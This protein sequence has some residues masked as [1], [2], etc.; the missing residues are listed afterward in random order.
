MV[1]SNWQ[2]EKRLLWNPR[3]GNKFIV[4][5]G[6][7]I[8]LY[9]WT[10]EYPEIR[11]I[12]S[13]H[14]L[15]YM[16][17]FAW[18][19]DPYFDD[20]VAVGNS[21]GRVDL[22]RL[23]ASKYARRNNVL[24]M[25]PTISFPLRNSR[26]CNAL[27]FC[28]AD[29]NYL[30]V[31]LDKAR[32]DCSL[33]IYDIASSLPSMA[34][35]MDPV[36]TA[37]SASRPQP[38]IPR[39]DLGPRTD[40][41]VLQQHA[42]AEIVSALSFLPN[43]T[44]LLLASISSR[45]LRLFDLRSPMPATT[46]VASKVYG[47]ATDPFEPRRIATFGDGIVAV[48]DTRKF[49]QPLLTF[50]E[51]DASAADGAV[52]DYTQPYSTVEF[53]STRRGTLAT[54]E[55]NAS[56]VR[57]W[58]IMEAQAQIAN[59]GSSDGEKSRDSALSSRATKRSWPNLPWGGTATTDTAVP[60]GREPAPQA[61]VILYDTHQTKSFDRPLA[62]FALVPSTRAHPLS[63]NIMVVNKDGDLELHAIYDTPKQ[64]SWSA[65]G[66][67]A[68]GAGLSYCV[69]SAVKDVE[70]PPEPWDILK[71]DPESQG[72]SNPPSRSQSRRGRERTIP[73]PDPDKSAT[74]PLFG[75]GD[76]EGFPPLT[77]GIAATKTTANLAATRPE[78]R[79]FSPAS[80]R[81]H[82]QHL[83]A[84]SGPLK[85][86]LSRPRN[87]TG[88]TSDKLAGAAGRSYLIGRSL[89]R[90]KK[91]PLKSVAAVIQA[92]ISMVM[93]RRAIRGY[94]LSSPDHNANV[95]QDDH[96]PYDGSS[97]MLSDVWK[98]I[99]YSRDILCV[100]TSKLHGYDFSYEGLLSIWEGVPAFMH[101]SY[102][103]P[104]TAYGN[105]LN[106]ADASESYQGRRTA[107]PAVDLQENFFAALSELL[108][109]S[110]LDVDRW[111]PVVTTSKLLQRQVALQLTGWNL[112]EEDLMMDIK[113]WEG[114]GKISRAACWLVFTKH[115]AKA[116]EL[117]LRSEDESHHM[118]SG[119]L[120][121]LTPHGSSAAFRH[122]ELRERVIVK[123]QDPYFRAMLVHLTLGDWREVLDEEVLPFRERL[124]IAFQF[125]D[126]KNL[127]SYLRRVK[128]RR[129]RGDIDA[130]IVTGLTKAGIDLLQAYVDKSGDIQT[131][132]IMSSYVCPSKFSDA[133][134]DRWLDAYRDLL[135][136]FKLFHH[137]V[138]FDISRGRI[139]QG[140][141][142]EGY[143]PPQEWV[144]R[145][146]LIRCNYCNKHLSDEGPESVRRGKDTCPH[147][148][149][150]LPRCSV[151]LMT[152]SVIPDGARDVELARSQAQYTDTIDDAIVMCQTCRHGG[153]ASHILDW[154]FG[155]DGGQYHATCAVAN[156][157]CT[158]A[159][160]F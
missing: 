82:D 115:Y 59:D 98:W 32:G 117:L 68:I 100:P 58:D 109:R 15:Q 86:S 75:R 21:S 132:A 87:D 159:N 56:R 42:P 67:L 94:G 99:S 64:T 40:A 69:L 152:L 143:M 119:I 89:S 105:T 155:E 107:S 122:S 11:H 70:T 71:D 136:G 37:S 102:E 12:T 49:N 39:A 19:P 127:T 153:H 66:D 111:K 116:V 5:G 43:S 63:S 106:V 141:F 128:E 147:C 73:L 85:R 52:R 31:G 53:S 156:C 45:W 7:Q 110:D 4:G 55:R 35:P 46:N 33:V 88:V 29:P 121:A 38:Q 120:A 157:D 78:K 6:S 44:S 30:A 113:R 26:S 145:Q 129:V 57:M 81:A 93:R 41:R 131:A 149:R 76:E 77:G 123:L 104:T 61:N 126:D 160:E 135:D 36:E 101:T 83:E 154:F 124:A 62:S 137:R 79:S 97:Q 146:I 16:K 74:P 25:G 108:D 90:G 134:V 144:P 9:E 50:T 151:C 60:S 139:I 158:C 20:L 150:S 72:K 2:S 1:T 47:I 84:N 130:M 13:Q 14:D 17:C 140:A 54:L 148:G 48:W 24:S 114:D 80:L 27:S 91:Q 51:R 103:A 138:D 125:L 3:Q 112:R 8:T 18:S 10:E 142:E 23:E 65:R 28:S 133:R 22:F 96:D 95:A 34:L 92:D 118:M